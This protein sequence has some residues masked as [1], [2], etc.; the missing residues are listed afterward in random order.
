MSGSEIKEDVKRY[1]AAIAEQFGGKSNSSCCTTSCSCHDTDVA[2][3]A[4]DY[5]SQPGY[6]P[7][8]D[9]GL[10]CGIPVDIAGIK[11]GD[12]VVDL[13]SGAGNDVFIARH[14]VGERGHV[15]GVDM[16]EAMIQKANANKQKLGLGNIEFRLGEIEDLPV[17]S[18]TADVVI[19]NCV[20]NLVPSKEKAFA[21][22]FRVLKPGGHFSISDVVLQGELPASIAAD[23]AM[24]AACVAGALQREDYLSKIRQTGFSSVEVKREKMTPIPQEI[25]ARYV[26]TDQAAQFSIWSI[27]VVG[28]KEPQ[29]RNG[30]V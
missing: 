30:R 15:I 11:Q 16:T 20:L 3:L 14:L 24:Y 25:L 2:Q 21:E 4:D 23:V 22:I 12:T 29:D 6:V 26:H 5:S 13:G 18:S 17:G 27:T 19:S 1:Y 8:A 28:T 7:E 10:G 9:L